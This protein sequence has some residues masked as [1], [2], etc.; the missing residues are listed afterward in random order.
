[1]TRFVSPARAVPNPDR[2]RTNGETRLTAPTRSISLW[3]ALAAAVTMLLLLIIILQNSQPSDLHFLGAH[4]RLPTGIAL[5]MA[6]ASG[7]LLVTVPA[8]IYTKMPATRRHVAPN[9]AT[10]S[11]SHDAE[12]AQ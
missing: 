6:M 2:R 10:V 5:L 3:A 4:G 1:M 7:A 12:S 11:P 8:L 9:T